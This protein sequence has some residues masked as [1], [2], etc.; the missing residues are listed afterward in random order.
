MVGDQGAT[1]PKPVKPVLAVLNLLLLPKMQNC[2]GWNSSHVWRPLLNLALTTRGNG[3]A[4]QLRF[5]HGVDGAHIG[6]SNAF[7]MCVTAKI[8]K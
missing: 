3:E 8:N 2:Q 6:C 1:A 7:G 4:G 5:L